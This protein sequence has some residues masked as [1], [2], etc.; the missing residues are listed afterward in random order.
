M[1]TLAPHLQCLYKSYCTKEKKLMRQPHKNCGSLRIPHACFSPTPSPHAHTHHQH[2]PELYSIICWYLRWS[3]S[4]YPHLV[5]CVHCL[6]TLL[7]DERLIV[8]QTWKQTA[9]RYS[10]Q[11]KI[12]EDMCTRMNYTH[13]QKCFLRF[14]ISDESPCYFIAHKNEILHIHSHYSWLITH[15]VYNKCTVPAEIV[16]S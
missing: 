14:L 11:C 13:F 16:M 12:R 8:Y 15:T 10:W 9:E 3:N 7:R 4:L 2:H 6:W 5:F 1:F